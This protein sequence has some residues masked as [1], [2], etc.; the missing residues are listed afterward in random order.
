MKSALITHTLSLVIAFSTTSCILFSPSHRPSSENPEAML[1]WG[2]K[3]FNA[4]T[5][6]EARVT[7]D[8][9]SEATAARELAEIRA[10]AQF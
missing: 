3:E 1:E 4:G 5:V 2:I 7:L 10:G 9:V 8:S 6:S